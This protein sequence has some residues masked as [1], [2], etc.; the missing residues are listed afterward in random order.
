MRQGADRNDVNA[1]S[2]SIGQCRLI[3][4]AGGL[5]DGPVVDD[6]YGFRHG[7]WIHIV[8]H[9]DIG[10]AGQRF[11]DAVDGFHFNLDFCHVRGKRAGAAERREYSAGGLDVVVLDQHG[12]IEAETV[13]DAAACAHGV[14]VQQPQPRRGLAGIGKA[15]TIRTGDG[16]KRM[17]AG[18][19]AGKM[20]KQIQ[21]E[22]FA[23]QDGAGRAVE[24]C[25]DGGGIKRRSVLKPFG[26]ADG[27]VK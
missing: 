25:N 16:G 18:G 8:Q 9:D 19:D 12:V 4:A 5:D 27:R 23:G 7:L 26:E 2:G 11:A 17:G 3:D 1:A 15:G 14:F 6:F 13:V 21:R 10:S 24:L 20:L 22:A